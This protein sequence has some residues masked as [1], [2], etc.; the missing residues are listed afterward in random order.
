MNRRLPE[1]FKP[2][3]I[4]KEKETTGSGTFP[5][6]GNTFLSCKI[7]AY[8][9]NALQFIKGNLLDLKFMAFYSL[10]LSDIEEKQIISLC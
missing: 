5:E 3:P 7:R 9:S 2:V 4:E 8:M 10:K 1:I 6:E